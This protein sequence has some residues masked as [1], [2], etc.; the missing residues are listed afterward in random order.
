MTKFHGLIQT[1]CVCPIWVPIGPPLGSSVHYFVIF[2]LHFQS[3]CKS[4]QTRLREMCKE[5][6]SVS[7]SIF[8]FYRKKW[9][10]EEN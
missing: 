1:V 8:L 9:E 2:L 10:P 7:G 6:D 3:H 5:D 4:S